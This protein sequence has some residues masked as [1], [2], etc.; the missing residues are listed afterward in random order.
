[1]FVTS[2]DNFHNTGCMQPLLMF[3]LRSR[4]MCLYCHWLSHYVRYDKVSLCH[5]NSIFRST[6]ELWFAADCVRSIR[7][8]LELLPSMV[9]WL[10]DRTQRMGLKHVPHLWN[11]SHTPCLIYRYKT[12]GAYQTYSQPLL[13][14]LIMAQ[15]V[16]FPDSSICGE[17]TEGSGE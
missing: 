13:Y 3:I 2:S 8:I 9:I 14:C 7:T 10:N 1:M 17:E 16:W 6:V 12:S 15:V 5:C 4:C 11:R